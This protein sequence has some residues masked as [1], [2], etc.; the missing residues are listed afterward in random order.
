MI[1][2]LFISVGSA[3]TGEYEAS[4][5]PPSF[6]TKTDNGNYLTPIF[7][8]EVQN[9]VGD[10][11]YEWSFTGGFGANV[12][13]NSKT[14]RRTN[15]NISSSNNSVEITLSCKVVDNGNGGAEKTASSMLFITFGT[16][17]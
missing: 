8:V 13:I 10:F 16:N 6:A 15:L 3:V 12:N 17:L 1:K 14:S 5:S 11:S 7:E 4:I 9:G 2:N